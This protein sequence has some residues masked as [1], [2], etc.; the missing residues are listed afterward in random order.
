MMWRKQAVVLGIASVIAMGAVACRDEAPQGEKVAPAA[1]GTSEE[2]AAPAG[3]E[4][5]VQPGGEQG[6][7]P[8]GELPEGHPPVAGEDQ[9]A[10]PSKGGAA[11]A[12]RGTRLAGEV[13]ETMDSGGYTYA[14]LDTGDGEA[15]VAVKQTPVEVGEEMTVSGA[16]LMKGFKSKTLDRTFDE[17]YFAMDAR[18]GGDTGKAAPAHGGGG[19]AEAPAVERVPK[20]EGDDAYT[21]AEIFRDKADL[22]GES[23]TVRGKVVKFN[24]GIM[25]KNWVH[26]QD[27]TG[28]AG[29]NDL[30]FTTQDSVEVGDVVTMT[31]TL[32]TDKDFG[33]GYSYAVI[34]EEAKL[35]R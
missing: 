15:W 30:T 13:L 23:V 12:A 34:V 10:R 17:I 5:G 27:G 2:Q 7:Q 22:A 1:Q 19:T 32:A 6:V 28:A 24:A 4:Q 14:K 9:P 29:K 35:Q 26:L 3:G 21:I 25:G 16:N 33:A 11:P 20:A 18:T 31:G 8:A